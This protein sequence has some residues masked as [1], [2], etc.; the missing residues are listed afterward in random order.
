M[1]AS[2]RISHT[3]E[4]DTS[5]IELTAGKR[6][7]LV[8]AEGLVFC[9]ARKQLYYLNTTASY[10][11]CGLEEGLEP[12]EIAQALARQFR[13]STSQA[14]R[15]VREALMAWSS[16]GLSAMPSPASAGTTAVELSGFG[17]SS[18]GVAELLKHI[19]NERH[20][21][22]RVSRSELK[23]RTSNPVSAEPSAT[24]D[25][26]HYL[27]GD[28]SFRIR[29]ASSEAE[30]RVHP[31]LAHLET[32][33]KTINT[34]SSISIDILEDAGLF[35]LV[36]GEIKHGGLVAVSEIVPMI[37]QLILT[38]AYQSSSC[39]AAFHSGAVSGSRG[40]I[41]LLG[42]PGSGKSTL[43]AA[44]MNSGLTYMTDELVLLMPD[45]SLCPLPI[46]IG[47]KQGAWPLLTPAIPTLEGLPGHYQPD[48]TEVRYLNPPSAPFPDDHPPLRALV[49]PKYVAG[50][51][52]LLTPVSAAKAFHRL[53]MSGY[54][55]PGE[56]D[57]RV[58]AALIDWVSVQECYELQ[59]GDLKSAVS[60]VRELIA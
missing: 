29:F 42:A 46:S 53:A 6:F 60:V 31:A 2:D 51:Q 13:V 54:A 40:C 48:G 58:V 39:L 56:L 41:L 10:I 12:L 4:S 50:A 34:E 36:C 5:F 19:E 55:V 21:G 49:F 25:E 35:S 14:Y 28:L 1:T 38:R 47:L 43:I 27:I 30:A 37:H 8:G 26:H 24:F 3:E 17:A 59:V 44:L 45:T 22:Y 57:S 11:W 23:P 7:Y 16:E 18:S 52:T 32:P 20:L 9:P 15:D 33:P